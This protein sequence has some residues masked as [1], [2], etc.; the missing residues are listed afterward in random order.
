MVHVDQNRL[1]L[2]NPPDGADTHTSRRVHPSGRFLRWLLE[3]E[4]LPTTLGFTTGCQWSP[5]SSDNTK[6]ASMNWPGPGPAITATVIG[7]TAGEGVAI[8]IGEKAER[9]VVRIDLE[10]YGSI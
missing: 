7:S 2:L 5:V 1:L 3:E 4:E 10:R 8:S 6:T 9:P